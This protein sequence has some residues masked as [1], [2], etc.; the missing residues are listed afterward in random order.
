MARQSPGIRTRHSRPCRSRQGGSCNC[1][2]TY[3]AW[4]WSNRD[5]KKIRRAF[6]N[7]AEAKG[8]RSDALGAVR[9]G[10]LRPS[11]AQTI[12]QAAVAWIA[13]ARAGEIRKRGARPYKPAVIRGYIA[14]LERY[15]VPALGPFRVSALRRRD[16]QERLVDD[17][18]GRSLSG[19]KVLGVVNALRAV[20][21]PALAADELAVNP[22]REL[23]LP[24]GAAT[25]DRVASPEEAEQLLAA[26]PAA[27]RALWATAFYAGLRRGELRALRWSDLDETVSAIHVARG[28][29]EVDGE[30][31]PKSKKGIRRVPI[32]EPLRIRLLE[33]KART[34]RRGGDLVFGRSAEAP[35]TPTHVR[36]CALKA[37]A[38]ENERRAEAGL[39]PLSPIGLHECRHTYVSLMFDAG[40]PLERIGDYV[41]HTTAHMTERYRHLIE[42]HETETADQFTEYLARK[43]GARNGAQAVATSPEPAPLSEIGTLGA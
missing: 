13:K 29:D 22:T 9:R 35:F 2:P 25:R 11:P 42:G 32:A 38:G 5:G 34:G 17:L 15:V 18:V 36:K 28:W 40:I 24:E 4:V 37:W 41:G 3:E 1:T 8:W 33:L 27:D 21:R 7:L 43:T 16:V 23:D 6:T 31:E 19:S 12:E 10:A 26:L 30:I 20:L 14:D 39:E